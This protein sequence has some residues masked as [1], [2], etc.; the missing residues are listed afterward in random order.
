[1]FGQVKKKPTHSQTKLPFFVFNV[2]FS[3]FQ[4]QEMIILVYYL[5]F[6]ILNTQRK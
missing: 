1:M 4:L 2:V 5:N 6:D 3:S